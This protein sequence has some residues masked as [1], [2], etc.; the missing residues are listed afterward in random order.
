MF[1]F[2][3]EF[4]ISGAKRGSAIQGCSVHNQWIERL[5][6]DVWK[7]VTKIF[8][9]VKPICLHFYPYVD[10]VNRKVNNILTFSFD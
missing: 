1:L 2:L 7:G 5:W 8:S 9:E 4:S 3:Q 6:V 10:E